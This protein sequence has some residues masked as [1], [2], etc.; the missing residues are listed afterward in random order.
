MYPLLPFLLLPY[1]RLELPGWGKLLE[2]TGAY[3]PVDDPTWRTAPRV[4][5]RGKSHGYLMRLEL[6]DFAQR[7]TFFLG[8]YSEIGVQSVLDATLRPGDRFVDIGSNIGMFTL[9][10]RSLIGASGKID[11][12][13]PN[14]ECVRMLREHLEINDIQNV[15]I[16]AC[17][18]AETAGEMRLNLPS[19]HSGHATFADVAQPLGAI[20][21][22][23]CIGDDL[24]MDGRRVDVIKIDVEGFELNVLR[25]LQRTLQAWN[26]ILITELLEVHLHRAGTC[27]AAVAELLGGLGYIPYGIGYVRKGRGHELVLLASTE[28]FCDVVWIHPK[29]RRSGPLSALVRDPSAISGKIRGRI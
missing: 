27:A 3:V 26:P 14:P 18:L 29:D 2:L 4:T 13:E 8:R 6:S 1:T 15:T 20:E 9:H 5:T 16:H 7:T 22:R 25:G 21:V 12:F 17:G 19:S 10:A 24:L 11:C 28:G 23:V